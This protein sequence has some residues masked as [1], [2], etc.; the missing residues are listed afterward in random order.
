[1]VSRARCSVGLAVNVNSYC[2]LLSEPGYLVIIFVTGYQLLHITA[3]FTDRAVVIRVA[4][5]MGQA[6]GATGKVFTAFNNFLS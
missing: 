3:F 4:P 5:A 2:A 1:M 6:N